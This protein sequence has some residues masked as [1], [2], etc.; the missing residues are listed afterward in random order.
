VFWDCLVL[1]WLT[2]GSSAD[3]ER[4]L[5]LSMNSSRD[6]ARR[7]QS[8]LS[9]PE[10]TEARNFESIKAPEHIHVPQSDCLDLSGVSAVGTT[11]SERTQ[12]DGAIV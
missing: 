9:I 6:T 4:S 10:K 5:T 11:A 3:A 1:Y 2:F 7:K 8:A 12:K